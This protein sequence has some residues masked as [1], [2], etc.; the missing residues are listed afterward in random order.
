MSIN[1]LNLLEAPVID[2]FYPYIGSQG[3]GISYSK[4]L[5]DAVFF[6][7][8]GNY[9][10]NQT[11]KN[12]QFI[13]N[14]TIRYA[15]L[16][17]IFFANDLSQSFI[18]SNEECT[19]FDNSLW[20]LPPE[21]VSKIY[22]E[23][24]FK[25]LPNFNASDKKLHEYYSESVINNKRVAGYSLR[26]PN[27][28][29]KIMQGSQEMN[30]YFTS[31]NGDKYQLI[32]NQ[33]NAALF[34]ET[35]KLWEA[36]SGIHSLC[37]K[38]NSVSM[39]E[40]KM[41]TFDSGTVVGTILIDQK[42]SFF[43]QRIILTNPVQVF[44]NNTKTLLDSSFTTTKFEQNLI[45]KLECNKSKLLEIINGKMLECDIQL[46]NVILKL[47]QSSIVF[48]NETIGFE[49]KKDK[50]Y[51]NGK[52]V[53]QL[54]DQHAVRQFVSNTLNI[55]IGKETFRVNT[56]FYQLDISKELMQLRYY[57]LDEYGKISGDLDPKIEDAQIKD[58]FAQMCD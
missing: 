20:K 54:I 19:I 37:F 21:Y 58:G 5:D 12:A 55:T 32:Q 9:L 40:S 56:P 42:T 33:N 10:F 52:L 11:M 8:Q 47:N 25:N 13:K 50:F 39:V 28:L 17:D 1:C 57:G 31:R 53:G 51:E 38:D 46:A 2:C 26:S 16:P 36:S 15:I 30:L 29:V 18:Y 6:S 45:E 27:Q 44:K 3:Y 34:S 23:D 14:G 49:Y 7:K 43:N 4:Y 48:Q 24:A 22:C 35:K 41:V